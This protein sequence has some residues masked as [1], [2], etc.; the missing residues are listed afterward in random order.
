M[1]PVQKFFYS[2]QNDNNRSFY[3]AFLRVGIS[4]WLLKELCIDLPYLDMLYGTNSFVAAND[5]L[6]KIF[7]LD[8]NFLRSHYLVILVAYTLFIV[9]NVFGI[10]RNF[11]A[12]SVFL[13]TEILFRMNTYIGHGGLY[14]CRFILLYLAFGNTYHYFALFKQKQQRSTE[15]E[16]TSV[17]FTNL[18]AY[19]IMLH[20]CIVY[21]SSAFI[22][23]QSAAWRNGE[24]MYYI[25][26]LEGY[27]GTGHNLELARHVWLVKLITWYTLV[28]EFC[29][30]FFVWI[31]KS[32]PVMITMGIILHTG[33]YFVMMLYGFQIVFLLTYGLF[34]TNREW[35]DF[36]RS[37]K[38]RFS[39]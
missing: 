32:R 26:S 33:I 31:K 34:F 6:L 15:R 24:M 16:K 14:L 5:N 23:F 9:A 28:F 30:P 38:K 22:K 36:L 27:D 12:F 20:L 7:H 17:F 13:L 37:I 1:K 21:F 11:T 2:L 39:F 19:A 3:L 18:S 29:F 4:L 8:I 25:F 35:F 10:G